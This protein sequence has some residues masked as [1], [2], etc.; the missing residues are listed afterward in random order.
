MR[1]RNRTQQVVTSTEASRT[2]LPGELRRL[3][4]VT[5]D[6]ITAERLMAG[7]L[8]Y[9]RGQGF[10]V[11]VIASPG[12]PLDTVREREGVRTIAVPM[13]RAISPLSDIV[14]LA[15]LT[16]ALRRL[17]PDVVSA[18]TPKAGLLGTM[19]GRLAGVP[20]VVYHLRGL[21][22]ET[23]TGL[24]RRILIATEHIASRCA[25]SVLCNGDSLRRRLVALGCARVEKTWVPA[26]G[27]SNGV[28]ADAFAR[29]VEVE[30][31][32]A[33]ERLRRGIPLDAVV[34]GFTGRFTRDKGI[35][36]LVEM[37]R[38]VS[39]EHPEL[40]LLLVGD[41]DETDPVEPE[42]RAWLTKDPRVVITGFVREP[43]RFYSM[44]DVF[45]FPSHREGFPNAPIEAAANGLPVLGF[46]ATGTVDAV[47]SGSTGVL[48]DVGDVDELVASLRTYLAEPE[49]RRL[50]GDAGRRRVEEHYRREVVWAA[51]AR[52]YARLASGTTAELSSSRR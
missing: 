48:V 32:A 28:D 35:A 50:H 44:M 37:F 26:Q 8:A 39:A 2:S 5:T 4:V 41:F 29:S 16:V 20:A 11:T 19:A 18:G 45:V 17:A 14:S 31:W 10:D 36:E 24:K 34:L 33:A 47:V 12:A 51:L 13:R 43:A 38:R 6:P 15:R 1:G 42:V 30:E 23:A 3:A 21:R 25:H 27:T 9:L 7:Q 22:F 40:R 46:R 49:L 52:G